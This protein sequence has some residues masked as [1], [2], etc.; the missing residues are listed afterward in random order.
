MPKMSGPFVPIPGEVFDLLKNETP[1]CFK[2]YAYMLNAFF[3]E[4]DF[5]V[6]GDWVLGRIRASHNEI[7]K[8]LEVDR[9]WLDQR[10]WPILTKLGIVRDNQGIIELPKLYK[11]A[12]QFIVPAEVKK[13][14][15]LLRQEISD[16]RKMLNNLLADY[17]LQNNPGNTEKDDELRGKPSTVEGKT[18]NF[19]GENPQLRARESLSGS[20]FKDLSLRAID[21]FYTGI[22]QTKISE[23]KRER[24]LEIYE[25]L[26]HDGFT[27]DQ[28]QFAVDW[29]VKNAKEDLY[30]F[31][32][33]E[34]TIGQ[35][36]AEMMKEEKRQE[37]REQREREAAEREQKEGEEEAERRRVLEHKE[38]LSTAERKQLRREAEQ[39]IKKSGQ[40]KDE[41]IDDFILEVRE[42]QILR[43]RLSGENNIE[44]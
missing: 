3:V 15:N 24:G 42:N 32:I 37:R 27:A 43:R 10:I 39:E 12:E 2:V 44:N 21:D 31:S 40:Y 23:K 17:D 5:D 25:K 1:M 13:Q 28:I 36:M 19:G 20:R 22:G 11:K 18:L 8:T 4:E 33:L 35:A 6:E 7:S 9:S 29:T 38:S 34:H 14:F 26:L 16:L 41:F 30:D